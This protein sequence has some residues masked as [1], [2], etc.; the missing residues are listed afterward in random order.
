MD[1]PEFKIIARSKTHI[2]VLRNNNLTTY[3]LNH[4][5]STIANDFCVLPLFNNYDE[6]EAWCIQEGLL[7]RDTVGDPSYSSLEPYDPSN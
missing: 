4:S 5:S 6:C 7:V 3:M 2:Y 1:L